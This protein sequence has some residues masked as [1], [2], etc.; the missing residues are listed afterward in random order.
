MSDQPPNPVSGPASEPAVLPER[1]VGI[2]L[3]VAVGVSPLI[4]G[5][6]LLLPGYSRSNREAAFLWMGLNFMFLLLM[7]GT[8]NTSQ[9]AR[10][11]SNSDLARLEARIRQ[12][13][14]QQGARVLEI[15][16]V[17][18]SPRHVIG[19]VQVQDPASPSFMVPWKCEAVVGDREDD[20]IFSCNPE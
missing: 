4:F 10:A 19:E 13:V 18:T 1:K 15:H 7:L 5:W 14:S 2:L 11:F 8:F 6:I 17:K 16:F 3:A 9:G 20:D 12:N